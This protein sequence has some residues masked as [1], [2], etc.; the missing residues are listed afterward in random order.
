MAK[1]GSS[2]RTISARCHC[3][4]CKKVYIMPIAFSGTPKKGAKSS[5]K[6][7]ECGKRKAT[8]YLVFRSEYK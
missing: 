3:E 4:A 1:E 5:T 6:C 2:P 8:A 7:P